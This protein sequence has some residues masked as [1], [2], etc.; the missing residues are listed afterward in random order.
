[1]LAR[2]A[3]RSVRRTV[4][5]PKRQVRPFATAAQGRPQHRWRHWIVQHGASTT[6]L[7]VTCANLVMVAYRYSQRKAAK[8]RLV[9]DA[10]ARFAADVKAKEVIDK[11]GQEGTDLSSLL[12]NVWAYLARDTHID[13]VGCSRTHRQN[14]SLALKKLQLLRKYT[15]NYE[16]AEVVWAK[17]KGARKNP[18]DVRD[19]DGIEVIA[20]LEQLEALLHL[21]LAMGIVESNEK[22]DEPTELW[23]HLLDALS[24][25][26]KRLW[27]NRVM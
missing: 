3:L 21:M 11:L 27:Y 7:A 12:L 24:A 25:T 5:M 6:V 4:A 14:L 2:V 1:M 16:V 9:N 18:D 17:A 8:E 26:R 22:G 20:E 19:M 15:G 10:E 23:H 13:S